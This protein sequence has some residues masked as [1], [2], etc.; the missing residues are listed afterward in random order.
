MKQIL[1][2]LAR[3]EH[4]REAI[5]YV[6]TFLETKTKEDFLSEPILRFA[7][8]R[9]LEIIGEAAN[10]LSENI[11]QQAPEIEWR[12]IIAF[13]NLIVHE[14][15]GVDLELVWSVVQHKIPQLGVSVNSLILNLKT[16]I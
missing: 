4:I 6:E 16:N 12:K 1:S 15:F 7:V 9:Q 10:H 11:L 14:Y 2:D 8:E 5:A 3:L 13:R